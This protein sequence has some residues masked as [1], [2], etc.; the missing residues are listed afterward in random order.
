MAL[1]AMGGIAV[2]KTAAKIFG[3]TITTVIAG[4]ALV[5]A[6]TSANSTKTLNSVQARQIRQL[7]RATPTGTI[8]ELEPYQSSRGHAAVLTNV[9][10]DPLLPQQ[11]YNVHGTASNVPDNGSLYMVIHFYGERQTDFNRGRPQYYL[12]A[13][14]LRFGKS[15]VNQRWAADGIYIGTKAAPRSVTSYRLS[16]YFCNSI[17]SKEIRVAIQKPTIRNFGLPDLPYPSCRQLDSIFVR[18]GT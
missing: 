1:R 9:R 3:W 8:T 14:N 16:L 7:E 2:W 4:A 18:R 6:W 5:V 15:V 17:D 10:S 11:I 13:A 12:V